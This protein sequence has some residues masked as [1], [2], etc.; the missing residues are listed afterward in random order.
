VVLLLDGEF[1]LAGRDVLERRQVDALALEPDLICV[2]GRD[3]AF[4]D[5]SCLSLLEQARR[6]C[7]ER[8]IGFAVHSLSAV[9]AQ[10]ITLAGYAGLVDG[11][12]TPP[13]ARFPA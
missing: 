1:D 2:D 11:P 10:L 8:G 9:Q 4:V 3:L 6:R 7:A 13:A 5:A 12:T